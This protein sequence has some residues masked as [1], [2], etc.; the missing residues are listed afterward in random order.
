MNKELTEK[1]SYLLEASLEALHEES[2]EWISEIEFWKR[3][4]SFFS[5]LISNKYVKSVLEGKKEIYDKASSRLKVY[6]ENTLDELKKEVMEQE[7]ILSE[8]L[9]K[10]TSEESVYR[11]RHKN[12]TDKIRNFKNEYQNIKK[13]FFI[14]ME[15]WP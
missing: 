9:K 7:K 8:N 12:L 6:K 14:I 1:W 10:N 15:N 11:E 13:D 2:R 5:K 3:E 4:V